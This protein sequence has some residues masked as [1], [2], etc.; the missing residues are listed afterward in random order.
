MKYAGGICVVGAGFVGQ[1]TG[2]GFLSHGWPVTFIDID[3]RKVGQL[4]AQ[5]FKAA[6]PAEIK[7]AGW[8][9]D[10]TMFTVNT[11]TQGKRINLQYIESAARDFG[12]R[13]GGATNYQLVVVRSTVVPGTTEELIMSTIE[14]ASG[15][16]AG[17]DFGVCMNPE[18]L[19]EKTATEDFAHPWIVVIGQY[20]TRSGDILADLYRDFGCPIH[21]LTIRQ[22]EMQKYVHNLYNA[23]KITFFNEM[24][25]VARAV[26][27][28]PEKMFQLVAKSAEGM[29]NPE[30]GIKDHGPFD[31]SCLPK[32]TQ[33]FADW[34]AAQGLPMPLLTT[35]IDINNALF[36]PAAPSVP[37]VPQPVRVVENKVH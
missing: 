4:Q 13:L 37:A 3:P 24:R 1:A 36:D 9:P 20:D 22:A 25:V 23:V 28:D 2:R 29:W 16:K 18:Y 19:R 21:R 33:A 35:A 32:D 8:Q 27:V 6:T 11:P 5:G 30:Y 17:R 7:K 12:E 31:G 34:A 15:K 10:V 14:E 26:G